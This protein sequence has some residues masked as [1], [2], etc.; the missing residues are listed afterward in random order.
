MLSLIAA[1]L[2][3]AP[4]RSACAAPLGRRAVLAAAPL[5]AAFAGA[6]RTHALN[7]GRVVTQL[8]AESVGG[9]TQ[10][11]FSSAVSQ[12]PI[13]GPLGVG[14]AQVRVDGSFGADDGK[15]AWLWLRDE[16]S[17][18]VVAATSSQAPPPF[19]I[20]ATLQRGQ[21]V[22]PLAWG[23]ECG[24]WEGDAFEVAVGEYKPTPKYAGY[25][26]M[27][28]GKSLFG[29]DDTPAPRPPLEAAFVQTSEDKAAELKTIIDDK[30]E[31]K[32]AELRSIGRETGE[33]TAAQGARVRAARLPGMGGR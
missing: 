16:E 24:V 17:G 21:V 11:D 32:G 19:A 5:A 4:P 1:A 15:F 20:K 8:D 27:V 25:P 31:R 2:A 9:R 14:A 33:W 28:G 3:L 26:K 7:V 30:Y 18:K 13:S 22:R 23:K 10:A 29:D 6:P 12:T